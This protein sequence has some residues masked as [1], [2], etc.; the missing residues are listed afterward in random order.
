[1]KRLALSVLSLS[2]MAGLASAVVQPSHEWS[3]TPVRIIALDIR[4]DQPI[5]RLGVRLS[6]QRVDGNW[7]PFFPSNPA[8]CSSRTTR[9]YNFS[10][11][12]DEETAFVDVE[13]YPRDRSSASQRQLLN[14][15]QGAFVTG[16]TVLFLMTSNR[17]TPTGARVVAGMR[18]LD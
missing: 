4:E 10:A 8:S 12:G 18:A 15:I 1:M 17:C 7:R 5:V 2:C 6:V 13:L 14:E 16:R 9:A 3:D 11:D